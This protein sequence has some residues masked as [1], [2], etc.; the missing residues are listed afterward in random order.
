MSVAEE[1]SASVADDL[2]AAWDEAVQPEEDATE[3]VAASE[4]VEQT[5]A[6]GEEAAPVAEGEQ[7]AA[8]EPLEP[9]PMWKADDKER[10]KTLPRE[11]QEFLLRRQH[12]S[13]ADYTRKTQEVAALRNWREVD[14]QL[15]PYRTQMAAEGISPQQ[16]VTNL[17][18]ADKFLRENPAEGLKWLSQRLGVDMS[19]VTQEQE[20]QDPE[21]M[22]MRKQL[23]SLQ[24]HIGQ[25]SQQEQRAA[26]QAA[27]QNIASFGEAQDEGKPA[28]PY[29]NDVLDDMIGIASAE[30]AAGR[31]PSIE[32]VY[33][34]ACWANTS[35]RDRLLADQ[36]KASAEKAKEEARAKAA[37]A[38]LASKSVTGG[39]MSTGN[40]GSED[41]SIRQQLLEN[42]PGS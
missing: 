24:S 20:Y 21:M 16:Y 1:Q 10:F 37:K 39:P 13:D 40:V 41:M 11:A 18:A 30:R 9:H 33:E 8:D 7:E 29:F 34:R 32:D 26:H 6:K 12:E 28:H 2:S 36:R 22:A 5:E 42:W 3:E 4:E 35:V 25:M 31:V 15:A 17:M 19:T 38:D 27:L 14:E 23:A